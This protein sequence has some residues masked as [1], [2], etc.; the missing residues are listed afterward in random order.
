MVGLLHHVEI[1]IFGFAYPAGGYF[2][3]VAIYPSMGFP[4]DLTYLQSTRGL[5]W[6]LGVCFLVGR[7]VMVLWLGG[8]LELP[9]R[10]PPVCLVSYSPF[11]QLIGM[12]SRGFIRDFL[13]L[14]ILRL[15]YCTL[16]HSVALRQCVSRCCL[17]L[18]TSCCRGCVRGHH[19]TLPLVC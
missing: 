10:L 19:G 1:E 8:K 13:C 17:L 16:V 5:L 2:V 9:P 11:H 15:P 12:M 14:R 18:I 4:L 3:D 6:W 7:L